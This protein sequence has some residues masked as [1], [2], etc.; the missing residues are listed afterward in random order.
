MKALTSL[1]FVVERTRYRHGAVRYTFH[2]PVLGVKGWCYKPK[3]REG[4][5]R[6]PQIRIEFSLPRIIWGELMPPGRLCEAQA[7]R[8]V[9]ALREAMFPDAVGEASEPW[10]LQRV[11]VFVD[12]PVCMQDVY[13]VYRLAR[14]PHFD[15]CRTFRRSLYVAWGRSSSGLKVYAKERQRHRLSGGRAP[16]GLELARVELTV[17]RLSRMRWFMLHTKGATAVDEWTEYIRTVGGSGFEHVR[18]SFE[19]LLAVL[20]DEVA[21]LDRQ[22]TAF[23]DAPRIEKIRPSRL[24]KLRR[25]IDDQKDLPRLFTARAGRRN[26]ADAFLIARRDAD[27]SLLH[28]VR[29][30]LDTTRPG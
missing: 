1:G 25:V 27:V 7:F 14:H 16:E 23:D 15:G 19:M 26:L 3:L 12:V 9:L 5:K 29:L 24:A 2:H 4:S 30:Y 8:V 17:R 11:D 28:A 20:V 22:E 21:E 10:T 13:R 18:I 6:R